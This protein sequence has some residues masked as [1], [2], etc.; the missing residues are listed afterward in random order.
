M[1]RTAGMGY[2]NASSHD[3]KVLGSGASDA[4]ADEGK[5]CGRVL[6]SC[7]NVKRVDLAHYLAYRPSS[8]RTRSARRA[9]AGTSKQKFY[10]HLLDRNTIDVYVNLRTVSERFLM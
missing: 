3:S 1:P 7:G 2:W 6:C 9:R 8:F 4:M 5:D 10:Q